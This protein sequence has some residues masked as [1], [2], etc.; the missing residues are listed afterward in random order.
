MIMPVLDEEKRIGR[1]LDELKTMAGIA[2][3]LVVDGGS[4]DRTVEIARRYRS[5]RV[6]VAPRGRGPQMNTGARSSSGK[7][8]LFL[9]ADVSLPPDAVA[10]V[11]RTLADPEVV[12]GAFRTWT[13][14][15]E[16]RSLL[17]P[18]LHLADIRSRYARVYYGDQAIFV[19][20]EVFFR[21]D[22]FPDQALMEDLELSRRLR[23][24]G[25]TVTVPAYVCVSG[26]RFLRRP[27]TY[28]A[29]VKLFP[30]LYRVGVPPRVLARFYE[31][32]R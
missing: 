31:P 1:R 23:Q 16:G 11:D 7:V 21:A 29:A 4:S 5:V 10:W 3:V 12:A 18:L 32:I 6:V 20:R 2:E 30:L 22:G 27:L 28:A 19:R 26:R 15:D 17:A 25:R 8:L 14:C 24:I 13:I 9:H